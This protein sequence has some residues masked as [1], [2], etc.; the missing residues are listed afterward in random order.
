METEVA[1]AR[2]FD[3]VGKIYPKDNRDSAIYST[4]F[5]N[6]NELVGFR[7]DRLVHSQ[8]GIPVLLWTV[9]LIGSLFVIAYAAVFSPTRLNII[10]ISGISISLGLVFL[11]ILTVDRP[12]KGKF[13]VSNREL[14]ELTWRFDMLDRMAHHGR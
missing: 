1:L 8:S 7:R 10:M 6:L 14:A 3:A 4:V 11:F 2:L 5:S 9:G 12:F 13:S